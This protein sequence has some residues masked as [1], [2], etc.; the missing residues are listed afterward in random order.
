MK[1]KRMSELGTPVLVP[2]SVGIKLCGVNFC[3]ER[4]NLKEITLEELELHSYFYEEGLSCLLHT[5]LFVRAPGPVRPQVPALAVLHE[6]FTKQSLTSN[7]GCPLPQNYS[8]NIRKV[9]SLI[10]TLAHLPL[11][12]VVLTKLKKLSRNPSLI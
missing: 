8:F 9:R 2:V 12:G 7:L 4:M 3:G 5:I 1:R 10:H 6:K 11:K